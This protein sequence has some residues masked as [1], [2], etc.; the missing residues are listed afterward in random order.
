LQLV[1]DAKWRGWATAYRAWTAEQWGVAADLTRDLLR[2]PLLAGEKETPPAGLQ[3]PGR[4]VAPDL[5][6]LSLQ[7]LM[8]RCLAD[9]FIQASQHGPAG[10]ETTISLTG[11]GKAAAALES[12]LR[13]WPELPVE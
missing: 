1:T 5:L 11:L 3:A 7:G 12:R 2:A 13:G 6:A 4:S 8:A 10:Q 9:G